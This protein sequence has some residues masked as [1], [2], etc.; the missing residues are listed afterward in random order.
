MRTAV[1]AAGFGFGV[2]VMAMLLGVGEV[3]LE[4]ARAPA[5]R[6]GGDVVVVGAAGPVTNAR[7][8]L[9]SV[10]GAP[11]LQEQVEVASPARR[12]ALRLRYGGRTVRVVA[13]AGVPSLERALGNPEIAGQ[14]R[15]TDTAA[16][17]GWAQPA[18]ATV[19]RVM[20]RFHPI[21]SAAGW[22]DSWAEWLYFN[23]RSDDGTTK[24]YLTFLVGPRTRP[25]SRAAGVRLQL[26]RG[27]TVTTF[28]AGAEVEEAA[29]L[30]FA[31]DLAIGGNRVRLDG[32][33]YAIRLDLPGDTGRARGDL[34]VT[35]D[36]GRSVPPLAIGGAGGWISGYTVPVLSGRVAGVI[37][38]AGA[39]VPVDGFAYHDHNWGFW[40]D[41]TWQWGQVAHD[42]LSFLYGRV[43]PPASA[44]DP[45]RVPGFL[46]VM[47]PDGPLGTASDVQFTHEDGPDGRP[48]VIGVTARGS[49]VDLVLRLEVE[50]AVA[51][52]LGGPMAQSRPLTFLQMRAKYHVTGTAAGRKLDF[53][54]EGAAETFRGS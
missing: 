33:R 36:A 34:V 6:G 2:A 8:V 38:V 27:G 39:P 24:F 4:Q 29:V 22:E 30:A 13:R 49:G 7:F 35:A 52:R 31:P 37:D 19:L 46:V 21:P 16:D 43:N 40:R 25:G 11:P 44:A 23:G 15:W 26:D 51:S 47:G 41:V 32:L 1:L 5:L 10:L 28:A 45:E 20:D 50:Q 54:A 42:G 14:P 53:E 17:A 9:G 48:R 3:V 18:A 12:A